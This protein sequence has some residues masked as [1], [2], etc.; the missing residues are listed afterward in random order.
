MN[1][2]PLVGNYTHQLQGFDEW[3]FP[4]GEL[5]GHWRQ[6]VDHWESMGFEQLHQTQQEAQLL[7]RETG[8]TYEIGDFEEKSGRPWQFDSLPFLIQEE[9][10]TFLE[11]ALKQRA[12]L[13]NAIFKDLYGSKA[14]LR[15]GLLPL[16]LVHQHASYI[17]ACEGLYDQWE[18]PLVHYAA[19][20]A[21][22]PDGRFFVVRD[23]TQQTPGAGYAIE[24]RMAMVQAMPEFFNRYRIRR[25]R[26]FFRQ[27]Q[28]G[29]IATAPDTRREPNLVLLTRGPMAA[30]HFEHAYFAAYLGIT[31]VQGEDLIFRDGRIWMKAL[32]GLKSVDVILRRVDDRDLDPLEILSDNFYGVPGL[33]EAVRNRSVSVINPAGA[34]VLENPGIFPYL[35]KICRYLLGEDLI[36]PMPETYWCREG[37]CK[38]KVLERMDQ[39]ML[40]PVYR[41]EGVAS[42][43][44]A[45][46]SPEERAQWA[47]KI[48]KDPGGYVGQEILNSSTLP[49]LGPHGIEPRHFM[50]RFFLTANENEFHVMP[51]GLSRCSLSSEV[52]VVPHQTDALA[53]DTW[54]LG[55]RSAVSLSLRTASE[56]NLEQIT[57]PSSRSAQQLFWVGR[58]A[59]RAELSLRFLRILLK[60]FTQIAE[61]D[62]QTDLEALGLMLPALTALTETYPG[63]IG[64]D[65][66][67]RLNEPKAELVEVIGNLARPGSL[68]YNLRAL[69]Q[70]SFS[71]RERW[72]N[73]TW[74]I[75]NQIKDNLNKLEVTPRSSMAYILNLLDRTVVPLAA[76]TGQNL[77]NMT[78]DLGWRLLMTGRRIERASLTAGLIP[79]ML[80]EARDP[81]VDQI[82]KETLLVA[83]ESL[84]SYRRLNHNSFATPDVLHF[85]FLNNQ[86]P[87]SLLYQLESLAEHLSYLPPNLPGRAL[88]EEGKLVLRAYTDLNLCEP[89]LLM[90][91]TNGRRE[92][93]A[94]LCQSI[95]ANLAQASDQINQTYFTHALKQH[96][97]NQG[98]EAP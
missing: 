4:D 46:L 17:R 69:L 20:I 65:C 62:A 43:I 75:L 15:Q 81:G 50:T 35:P 97:L 31:L 89:N 8:V 24:N 47:E 76:F 49:I 41:P 96:Q 44:G 45:K 13:F 30:N 16:E 84:I 3:F 42:A 52:S 25:L 1:Q 64:E 28:N 6:I 29:L 91:D 23:H 93:L 57:T 53:K 9:E 48:A 38:Q 12:R 60:H 26:D 73:D 92:A 88:K 95:T 2:K 87:R 66:E 98:E 72:S 82:A 56:R 18:T 71:V 21:R 19:D 85:L 80:V 40:S 14:L 59:E 90:V 11:N 32:D 34:G 55:H 22:G 63:F 27:M 78:Q 68:A 77:E 58:Y 61:E 86:N 10:W 39:M 5:R 51:G 79:S 67:A 83:L 54:V 70:A 94:Q 74:R 33:I 36:L 37:E 7:L